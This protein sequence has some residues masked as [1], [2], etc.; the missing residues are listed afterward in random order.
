MQPINLIKTREK[1]PV[2]HL[3][4]SDDDIF[5]DETDENKS[6]QESCITDTTSVMNSNSN[7][8][9]SA[10]NQ[11]PLKIIICFNVKNNN[12]TLVFNNHLYSF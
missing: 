5:G 3:E 1:P 12:S 4:E 9:G 6:T 11:M 10:F 7:D 8:D 2:I